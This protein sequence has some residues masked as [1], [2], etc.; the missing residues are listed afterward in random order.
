MPARLART[1]ACLAA[2]ASAACVGSK[3]TIYQWNGYEQAIYEHEKA[4]QDREA[5]VAS[6][7]TVIQTCRQNGTRI[8]PGVQAEYGYAL[9]E[10]GRAAESVPW[11]EAEAR[12]WPESRL[13]M[14]KM[15]RNA[16]LRGAMQPAG[17]GTTG[18]AG[19]VGG[20]P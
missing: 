19:A 15:V 9:Y 4:P 6:L 11:F 20:K 10:E 7:W 3:P 5:Y 12:D 17:P 8:P 2:L 1:A 18:P 16:Q 14:Q 13:L